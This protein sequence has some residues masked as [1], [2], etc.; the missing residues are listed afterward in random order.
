MS[1]NDN[2]ALNN[3]L[4]IIADSFA[5]NNLGNMRYVTWMGAKW[6]ITNVEILRPRLLLTIGSVYN[7]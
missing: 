7:G 2:L 4:S 5:I 6:N 1:I 3:Q